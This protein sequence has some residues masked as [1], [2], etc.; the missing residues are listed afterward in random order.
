MRLGRFSTGRLTTGRMPGVQLRTGR[1]T[2]SVV[3][4]KGRGDVGHLDL[5]HVTLRCT[6]SGDTA[7]G[8]TAPG[9]TTRTTGAAS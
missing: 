8:N 1:N 7:P 9:N 3:L 2:V 4:T 5:D 6:T